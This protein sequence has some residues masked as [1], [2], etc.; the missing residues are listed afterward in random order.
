[1]DLTARS[2]CDRAGSLCLA[3]AFLLSGAACQSPPPQGSTGGRID[4]YRTTA[5][6]VASPAASGAE[7]WAYSDQVAEALVRDLTK[8]DQILSSPT[9]VALELGDLR[10][11]T[12]TPTT[13]FEAIQHRI[14][15]KLMRSKIIRDH[16]IV[17]EDPHRMDRE[18]IR[19]SGEDAGATS[20]ARYDPQV[21]YLLMGDF[22]ELDRDH[23]RRY[24]FEFKLTNLASREIVLDS[25]YDLAQR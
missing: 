7:L 18:K 19:V 15:G 13:D 14:R 21:T 9:R 10:N 6:D 5:A 22:F 25:S 12:N 16:F 17:V 3:A 2:W 20:T 8:I 1:M 24:Y 23:T 11:M 4:P